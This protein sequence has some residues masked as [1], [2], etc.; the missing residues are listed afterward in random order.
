MIDIFD[1]PHPTEAGFYDTLR[2]S[3]GVQV[4]GDLADVADSGSSARVLHVSDP[5]SITE[6]AYYDTPGNAEEM[7][8]LGDLV[9]VA[10]EDVGLFILRHKEPVRLYLPLIARSF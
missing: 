1:P 6:V 8:V 4:V 2:S 7:V 10:D 5:V 9:Y 3:L